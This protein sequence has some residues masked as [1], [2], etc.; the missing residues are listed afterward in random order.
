MDE[1]TKTSASA[2]G[3]EIIHFDIVTP[4]FT[5]KTNSDIDLKISEV[6]VAALNICIA[7]PTGPKPLIKGLKYNGR[8][9]GASETLEQFRGIHPLCFEAIIE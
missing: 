2:L 7:H 4:M 8:T 9:L 5:I 3:R 6:V 1:A